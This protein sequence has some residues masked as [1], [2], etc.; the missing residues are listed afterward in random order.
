MTNTA[1]PQFRQLD[2]DQFGILVDWATDEGWDPGVHDAEIFHAA[3]PDGFYGLFIGDEMIGGGSLVSYQ[4]EFGFMGFFIV[5]PEYRSQGIGRGLWFQRRDTLLARLKPGAS[6]GMD[7]V[8]AMQPFYRQGG[9]EIAYR[10]ERRVRNG[11]IFA[12]SPAVSPVTTADLPE[13]LPYDRNCF[14]FE[15]RAFLER[16]L[17]DR[18]ARAFSFREQGKLAGYA[19]LRRTGKGYKIGPL[20]ADT[21]PVA[22]ELYKACLSAVPG[23][24]VFLDIPM[25]NTPAVALAEEFGAQYVFECARM[26]HGP[27]PE[28]RLDK[29]FGITTF[30]LG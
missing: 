17:F 5:R 27:E 10:D 13:I 23:Q 20:F 16:W 2:R 18:E 19:V 22:R 21:L 29:V 12:L 15:R 30:E 28:N 1:T 14:G 3:F 8:V 24:P 11:E 7:G 25:K 4:G 26:Y 9:F 6:I